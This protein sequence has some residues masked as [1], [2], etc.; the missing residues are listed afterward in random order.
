MNLA[1][2]ILDFLT[3]ILTALLIAGLA[4]G[5]SRLA[6]Q[7][8]L[9]L[10]SVRRQRLIAQ[11]VPV[12]VT[13][14]VEL[15]QI[16]APAVS[17]LEEIGFK[18]VGEAEVSTRGRP[19]MTMWVLAAPDG[20][21]HVEASTV[22]RGSLPIVLFV[23]MFSAYTDTRSLAVTAYPSGPQTEQPD[24]VAH[25]VGESLDE[26]YRHQQ[27]LV[28]QFRIQPGEPFC[29]DSMGQFI[30][31]SRIYNTRFAGRLG[32]PSQR[33]RL[34]GI[35]SSAYDVAVF[36][37]LTA[38]SI[39]SN[40]PQSHLVYLALPLLLSTILVN[41]LLQGTRASTRPKPGGRRMP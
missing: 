10:V 40:V 17:R 3:G 23:T 2:Q 9:W 41:R 13:G 25:T 34:R 28:G 20:L 14:Q 15:P 31:Y 33:K 7:A 35:A 18:R 26:A 8:V 24:Y 36:G 38:A 4:M 16:L 19:A 29:V 12:D 32:G 30:E 39:W 37:G 5:L 21:C 11:M 22:G 6:I 27:L 1:S